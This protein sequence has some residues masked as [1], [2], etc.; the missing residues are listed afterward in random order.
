MNTIYLILLVFFLGMNSC[1]KDKE[2]FERALEEDIAENQDESEGASDSYESTEDTNEEEDEKNDNLDSALKAF[3]TAYGGGSQASG[4]RGRKVFFVTSLEDSGPGS[5]RQALIDAGN[6]DG[7]TIL[8]RVSGTIELKQRTFFKINNVTIAGQSAP[9]GGI[10]LTG[11]TLVFDQSNNVI[12]RYLRFRPDF[13]DNDAVG[14]LDSDNIIVDHCSV[15]W[16]GDE[17]I[18]FWGDSDNVTLQKLLIAEGKTGSILGDSDNPS[19]S[20]NLSLHNSLFYNITHRFPNPNSNERIDVVNNVVFNW[21]YRLSTPT[22][23]VKLNHINNYYSLGC[24]SSITGLEN[25][26]FEGDSPRIYTSGNYVDKDIL[27]RSKQDNWV[28]WKNFYSNSQAPSSF[29]VKEPYDLLGDALPIVS[30]QEAFDVVLG[31]VGANV[32]LDANGNVVFNQDNLDVMFLSNVM[33][34]N[35]VEYESSS[36]SY[37]YTSTPHYMNYHASVSS[38]PRSSHDPNFDTDS[39]GMPDV[40]EVQVFGDLSKNGRQDSDGDGYSD[41]EEYLN[42]VDSVQ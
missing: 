9:K 41:L 23:N 27:T 37:S 32:V 8:F 16:G 40:W 18:T 34:K 7:G 6:N 19:I 2:V 29:N 5:F 1:Q 14:F 30:A 28:L 22:G 4:G 15:S 13:G 31:D 3:P 39:D 35:C 12:I 21:K 20:E 24:L 10:D 11:K 25:K 36:F 33:S 42:L 17:S 38:L 26:I